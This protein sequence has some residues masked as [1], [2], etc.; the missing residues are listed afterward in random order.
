MPPQAISLLSVLYATEVAYAISKVLPFSKGELERI[1]V[2]RFTI[3][4]NGIFSLIK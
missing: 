4:D 1:Y 2:T 3:M